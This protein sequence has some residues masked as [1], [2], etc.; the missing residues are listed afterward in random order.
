M[1]DLI[2]KI[3]KRW[4]VLA[5]A[6]TLLVVPFIAFGQFDGDRTPDPD[7]ISGVDDLW[8]FLNGVFTILYSLFFALAAFFILFA[9]FIY[10]TSGGDEEKIT[11]A[12]NVL[13][14]S[15]IAIV[16]AVIS[17]GLVNVIESF[18]TEGF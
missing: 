17:L 8:A 13:I 18:V 2:T 5:L 10:L 4:F 15:I 6:V 16:I 12:K 9:G 11:K 1:T 14:Y 3:D 7:V